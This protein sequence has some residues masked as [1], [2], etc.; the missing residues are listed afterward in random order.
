MKKNDERLVL[1]YQI[2]ELL[3]ELED[4][5]DNGLLLAQLQITKQLLDYISLG[6]EV[7]ALE[8]ATYLPF[9]TNPDL[10]NNDY[11]NIAFVTKQPTLTKKRS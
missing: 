4:Y 7:E 3:V 2:A 9:R 5:K 6:N 11:M 10:D 1:V 8:F